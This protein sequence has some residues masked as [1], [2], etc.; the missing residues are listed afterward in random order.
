MN[1]STSCLLMPRST[2]RLNPPEADSLFSF[3]TVAS[4]GVAITTLHRA[5][6]TEYDAVYIANAIEGEL[7][8]LRSRDS[9]L[10]TRLLNPRLPEDSGDYILF[11]LA[12]ERRLAYTAMTRATDKV[13][14]TATE[15]D[16]SSQQL[17]PSRF[18]RQV[19][20]QTTPQTATRPLT[21]RGYEAML[22]RRLFDPGEPDVDRL[23]A[24]QILG[25][26][27]SHGFAD[28]HSRYGTVAHGSDHGFVEPEHRLSPS[29]AT[30]YDECPRNY[31]LSRFG[32]RKA[33]ESVYL[34]FGTLIH[35]VLEMAEGAAKE[36]GRNRS[37]VGEAHRILDEIWDDYSFGSGS[38]GRAW[39]RR[40]ATLLEVL[41]EYWPNLAEPI[42]LETVLDIELDGTSWRGKVDRIER[43]GDELT[44]IDYKTSGTAMKVIDAARSLQLGYYVLAAMDDPG[45]AVMQFRLRW[46]RVP[47]SMRRVA[48]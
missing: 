47:L 36:S 39:L 24:L 43:A 12:E 17:E 28:Q 9:I 6:G 27:P 3:R 13:V 38:I 2:N 5:K 26:G 22:R 37:T 8:D 35:E 11:R 25:A 29:Q 15:T 14:W 7:P 10:K 41:Y 40:A 18:L 46:P 4:S 44:V 30:S 45:I 20:H 48:A 34:S 42:E 32:T 31:A 33:A 23:S 19:A 16:S 21:H 1:W